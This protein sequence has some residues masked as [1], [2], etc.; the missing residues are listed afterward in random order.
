[1][2]VRN[3]PCTSTRGQNTPRDQ[4]AGLER[5][6]EVFGRLKAPKGG[7]APAQSDVLLAPN[8]ECRAMRILS[9]PQYFR[10][11]QR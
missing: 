1:M 11:P 6:H 7:V 3:F 5:L 10:S 2:R 9:A 8:I 4:R